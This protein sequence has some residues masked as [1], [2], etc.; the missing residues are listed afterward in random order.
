[1]APVNDGQEPVIAEKSVIVHDE[2]LNID[3]QIIAGHTVPPDLLDAY[4]EKKIGDGK[5][6]ADDESEAGGDLSEQTRDR[7]NAIAS[8]LGVEEPDKLPNK[9]AVIEAIEAKRAEGS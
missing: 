4:N 1:M 8:D 2:N 7:L 5:A 3:R 9:D 6:P